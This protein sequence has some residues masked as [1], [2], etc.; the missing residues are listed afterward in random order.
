MS[1]LHFVTGGTGFVGSCLILELLAQS[2]A[3]VLC[4]VRQGGMDARDRLHGMLMGLAAAYDYPTTLMEQIPDR[5]IPVMGDVTFPLC[6]VQDV[7]SG[8]THF[9]HSAASLR[10]ENRYA[11]EIFSTNT[12]GTANALEIA[13]K[14]KAGFFGYISTAYVV[15]TR[16]GTIREEPVSNVENN[17]LYEQSKVYSEKMLLAQSDIPVLIF[18]PSIVIGHSRTMIAF[19]FSGMYGF[20]RKVFQFKRILERAQAGIGEREQVR[21]KLDPNVPSNLIPVDIVSREAVR[22]GLSGAPPAVYHLTHPNPPLTGE[23]VQLMFSEV[24]L[25]P[26]LFA[27]TADDFSWVDSKFN[28]RIDFYSSYIVGQ[29]VFDRTNTNRALQGQG[30]T[31]APLTMDR[32]R[33]HFQW[34]LPKLVEERAGLPV[35][36]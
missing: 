34:Y 24:G 26:P 36:R 32:L 5:C 33:E 9:W 6:G 11:D 27:N 13:R 22:I 30:P 1:N 7:P 17:N 4:L 19:N 3:K 18:R 29:K 20:L 10:Y 8:V 16:Q 21:I 31:I 23:I 25:R 35:T 15:G 28:E 14:M 2:D 12:N